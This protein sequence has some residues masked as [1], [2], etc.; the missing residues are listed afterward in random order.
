M[1]LQELKLSREQQAK[2]NNVIKEQHSFLYKWYDKFSAINKEIV[3]NFSNSSLNADST[4]LDDSLDLEV[5]RA[6]AER[7]FLL[8]VYEVLDEKQ[9]A[10]F[11]EKIRE[12]ENYSRIL[13]NRFENSQRLRQAEISNPFE[14]IRK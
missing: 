4:I 11:G 3:E 13:Q 8:S 10:I 5:E 7:N 12:R 6:W 1:E 9:R 14:E 2:L